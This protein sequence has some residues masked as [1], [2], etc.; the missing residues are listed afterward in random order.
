[1]ALG[2]RPGKLLKREKPLGL[3]RLGV[4]G[5]FSAPA[6]EVRGV[7]GKGV[8]AA[9]AW[10]CTPSG[11]M[12]VGVEG[13][14]LEGTWIESSF[15]GEPPAMRPFM[16]ALA[17]ESCVKS[18]MADGEE[19][20]AAGTAAAGVMEGEAASRG[21]GVE[22]DGAVMLVGDE[23]VAVEAGPINALGVVVWTSALLPSVAVPARDDGEDT[24]AP[25]EASGR[26]WV[27]AFGPRP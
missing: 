2:V 25:A 11:V 20:A 12:G 7:V 19:T 15:L 21:W 5:L 18:L 6:G 14:E 1:M 9:W 23:G 3:K 8:A 27:P 17:T 22:A 24:A 13:V 16:K 10:A 4:E 26:V